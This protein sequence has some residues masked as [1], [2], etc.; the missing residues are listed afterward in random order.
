MSPYLSIPKHGDVT[1]LLRMHRLLFYG[2][3]WQTTVFAV[4]LPNSSILARVA[5]SLH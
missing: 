2:N 5:R 3:A 4:I 1:Y